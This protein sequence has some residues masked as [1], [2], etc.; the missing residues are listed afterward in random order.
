MSPRFN[1]AGEDGP[2]AMMAQAASERRGSYVM[3]DATDPIRRGWPGPQASWT[4]RM[5]DVF[6][7]RYAACLTQGLPRP[8]SYT[9]AY[10]AVTLMPEGRQRRATRPVFPRPPPPPPPPP[11]DPEIRSHDPGPVAEQ[12]RHP[13]PVGGWRK[14]GPVTRR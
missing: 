5:T 12:K 13:M 8:E 11:I 6:E 9:R 2:N 4:P 10:Q 7:R 3:E 14:N 1:A